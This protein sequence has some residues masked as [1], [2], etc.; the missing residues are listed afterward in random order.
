MTSKSIIAGRYQELK[1]V[2]LLRLIF[3]I[4]P[5]TQCT[6]IS[7]VDVQTYSTVFLLLF[8]GSLGNLLYLLHIYIVGLL[9]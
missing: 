9:S 3:I 6:G 1:I 5:K 4:I 7:M 8:G 2:T